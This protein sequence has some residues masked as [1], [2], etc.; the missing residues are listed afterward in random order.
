MTAPHDIVIF[1]LES[2]GL[3]AAWLAANIAFGM[4]FGDEALVTARFLI[5]AACWLAIVVAIIHWAWRNS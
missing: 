4:I 3:G 5:N 1:V 2:F